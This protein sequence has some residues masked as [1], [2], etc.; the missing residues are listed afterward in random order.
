[1]LTRKNYLETIGFK[2]ILARRYDFPS[3]IGFAF[4]ISLRARIRTAVTRI[5]SNYTNIACRTSGIGRN[6]IRRIGALQ[7]LL[8]RLG[9]NSISVPICII[10]GCP[11]GVHRAIYDGE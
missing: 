4:A 6:T 8:N 1:M 3:K 10:N 5:E 9:L 2:L 7:R 11:L